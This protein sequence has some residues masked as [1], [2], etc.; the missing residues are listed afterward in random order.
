MS[1][2]YFLKIIKGNDVGTVFEVLDGTYHIMR[3]LQGGIP[4]GVDRKHAIFLRDTD[5]SKRHAKIDLISG[6]MI[7]TDLGSTNGVY[8]NRRR[9]A[10][11]I[12]LNDDKLRVGG[13]VFNVS[14]AEKGVSA[15]KTFVG[16]AQRYSKPTH[17]FKKLAK[18]VENDMTFQPRLNIDPP[19]PAGTK[20][21][22]VYSDIVNIA[23][24]LE[25]DKGI[26]N[27]AGLVKDYFVEAH[28]MDG[29]AK[30]EKIR[31]YRRV[32][33]IGRTG[34][35]IL[36]EDSVSR[37]HAIVEVIENGLFKL[38][39]LG[40]QNGTFINGTRI[41]VATFSPLDTI[42]VGLIPI[43]FSYIVEEEPK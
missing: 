38:K 37:E 5:I 23:L 7:I 15:D 24:N 17:E 27:R 12:L 9:V 26:E 39:D 10:K 40:S 41:Q 22:E 31:F 43:K 36:N 3:A 14:I 28:V 11:S 18:I 35:F 20:G 13:T 30:G 1:K 42:K 4:T 21:Y 34:D 16:D 8:V 25:D 29:K 33:T 32:I 2:N 19:Y 6:E